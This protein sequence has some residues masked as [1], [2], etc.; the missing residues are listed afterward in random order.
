[1]STPVPS[2]R[3]TARSRA[4][5]AGVALLLLL[6]ALPAAAVTRSGE[7]HNGNAQNSRRADGAGPTALAVEWVAEGTGYEVSGAQG[8]T[9]GNQYGQLVSDGRLI[10]TATRTADGVPMLLAF[11]TADGTLLWD[12]EGVDGGC[13]PVVDAQGDIWAFITDAGGFPAV[14]AIDPATGVA[15][16]VRQ[17]NSPDGVGGLTPCA[18]G[19]HVASN[20]LVVFDQGD[21]LVAID[22]ATAA[23]AWTTPLVAGSGLVMTDP[24]SCDL[25]A[26]HTPVA[27][28]HLLDIDPDT[29]AV[30]RTYE[31]LGG[32]F[33]TPQATFISDA[34]LAVVGVNPPLLSGQPTRTVAVDLQA[35][36]QQW[37]RTGAPEDLDGALLL[38]ASDESHFINGAVITADDGMTA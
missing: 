5:L 33:I 23:V 10:A 36:T 25:V 1:M 17:V 3:R 6:T 27:D 15:D 34:G 22:P 16:P 28:V 9:S 20:G 19:L 32:E 2:S 21:L 37:E 24:T 13:K 12:T 38:L 35:L 18:Y 14:A 11:D 30:E 4:L 26:F 7:S 31:Q 29:G 8:G